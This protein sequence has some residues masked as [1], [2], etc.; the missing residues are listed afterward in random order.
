MADIVVDGIRATYNIRGESAA[1]L[2]PPH[3]LMGGSRFDVRLERI[4][5]EL[6]KRNVSVLRFDYQRPFRSGIGEVED[7]KKC[8]AYLKDRHDKIAVIRYSFGS[9]VASNVA[10]YCDAAV[11]ISPLPEI[12]SIY[13]KDAEIPKLFIIATRDQFVSL[14]ESVKLYEQASK[15]K[16]VVKVETDHFYFGKFDF[17]AKITADFIERQSF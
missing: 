11:Y 6:T 3:P 17:I 12:N 5:A 9:V 1:L 7:A 15:P 10:E 14:E 16:E 8:V 13:F 4:A 2:C